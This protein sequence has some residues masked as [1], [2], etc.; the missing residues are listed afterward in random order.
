MTPPEHCEGTCGEPHGEIV[1]KCEEIGEL[2]G[3]MKKK[4][5][6]WIFTFVILLLIGISTTVSGF[7]VKSLSDDVKDVETGYLDNSVLALEKIDDLVEVVHGLRGDMKV[8]ASKLEGEIT[9]S[10][11]ED[12]ECQDDIKQHIRSKHK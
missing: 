6:S 5:S 8:F 9:R 3:D 7:V 12:K 11:S 1:T 10:T 4:L 2:K